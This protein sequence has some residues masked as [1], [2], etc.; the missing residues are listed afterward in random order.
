AADDAAVSEHLHGTIEERWETDFLFEVDKA[1]EGLD[2]CFTQSNLADS[3]D[4]EA[5]ARCF[6][7]GLH[8][9][10]GDEEV[11]CMILPRE[12]RVVG[13]ALARIDKDALRRSHNQVVGDHSQLPA[14]VEDFDYL[15]GNF[16]GLGAFFQRA[17]GAN[18][19]VVFSV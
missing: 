16:E 9:H 12:A 18:R 3:P 13:E 14:F 8:L 15:W 19:A 5:L 11:I 10:W 7:G 6:F 4:A 1:W 2:R 17:S